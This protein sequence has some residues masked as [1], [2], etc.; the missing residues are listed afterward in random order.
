MMKLFGEKSTVSPVAIPAS[1]NSA[2]AEMLAKLDRHREL[3]ERFGGLRL[4]EEQ[5][6]D[7]FG[8][9]RSRL[10]ELEIEVD[11]AD[12]ADDREAYQ[13]LSEERDAARVRIA[14]AE[15]TFGR[16]RRR[17]AAL[18]TLRVKLENEITDAAADFSAEVAKVRTASL[19]ALRESLI[20]GIVGEM[21]LIAALR[22]SGMLRA[23]GLGIPDRDFLGEVRIRDPLSRRLLLDG[24]RCLVGE[25][26]AAENLT[27]S[28]RAVPELVALHDQLTPFATVTKTAEAIAS[29]TRE[30]RARGAAFVP[31]A[32]SRAQ[33]PQYHGPENADTRLVPAEARH[34]VP[35]RPGGAIHYAT[36][37]SGVVGR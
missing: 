32:T 1:A 26:A 24:E 36:P 37:K 8:R 25:P 14:A 7:V 2:L 31:S 17:L 21:P 9:G 27:D 30:Q 15:E 4:E 13:R 11:I 28:W 3:G 18:G 19:A 29:Q 33:P 34:G 10:S 5:S 35:F 6:N 20:D 23:T 22:L 16:V 12:D